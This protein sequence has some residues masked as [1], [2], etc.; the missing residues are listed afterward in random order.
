MGFQN[1]FGHREK[2]IFGALSVPVIGPY[3]TNFV[4]VVVSRG[5]SVTLQEQVY[6]TTFETSVGADLQEFDRLWI[7]GLSNNIAARTSFVNPLSTIITSVNN[8][9]FTPSYGYTGSNGTYLNTNYN[10]TLNSVQYKQTSAATY[11]YSRTNSLQDATE[12]GAVTT[13]PLAITQTGCRFTSGILLG[14]INSNNNTSS[15]VSDS[16]RLSVAVRNSAIT[17]RIY[18][19]G[20][21]LTTTGNTAS[22]LPN[23]DLFLLCRNLNGSPN[24]YTARQI[25]LTACSS[26]LVNQLNFYNAVQAL[27][28]S[29][30][31]AV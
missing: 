30:G 24:F 11:V 20:V 21:F 29:I 19:N 13:G 17:N 31:W 4:N 2:I 27:G 12:L 15:I 9:L 6:L 18:K 23:V 16:I 28:T 7:H 3:T 14:D 22:I 25:S 8:P 5:G 1:K 10:L 26:S